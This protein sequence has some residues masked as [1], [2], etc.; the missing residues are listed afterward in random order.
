MPVSVLQP[1]PKH[2]LATVESFP[3]LFSSFALLN[4]YL[5]ISDIL[6]QLMDIF[7]FKV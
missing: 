1:E 3:L 5:S 6:F 2:A 4:Y 7:Y